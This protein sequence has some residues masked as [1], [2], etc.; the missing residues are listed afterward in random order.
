MSGAPFSIRSD[1]TPADVDHIRRIVE[2]TRFFHSYEVDVAIELIEERLKRGPECGYRFLFAD[3][4]DRTVGYACY[5]P[6]ACTQA[7]FDLYWIVVEPAHQAS[8][9]GRTLL[10]AC[11][12]RI[13]DGGGRR[14]YV[15][16][17]SRP[18]YQPTRTFYQRCG[19]VEEARLRD[20]YA[21]G[22]DKVVFVKALP[23]P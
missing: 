17:S 2:A 5:G 10:H 19:Y 4:T 1:P 14:V 7:S 22:D 23:P 20:F 12:T 15:E 8:G 18:L 9:V 11:E 16:T 3:A 13:A 6:I 21:D